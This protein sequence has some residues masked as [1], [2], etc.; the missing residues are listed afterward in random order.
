MG[1]VLSNSIPLAG[2]AAS[3]YMQGMQMKDTHDLAR[4][5]L[6]AMKQSYARNEAEAPYRMNILEGQSSDYAPLGQFADVLNNIVGGEP[7]FQS[8]MSYN[9][10]LDTVGIAAMLKGKSISAA[11]RGSGKDP[12]W[13]R[14][15][16]IDQITTALRNTKTRGLTALD[17][18]KGL[19]DPQYMQGITNNSMSADDVIAKYEAEAN[20]LKQQLY[21]GQATPAGAGPGAGQ[22]APGAG[23]PNKDMLEFQKALDA[24]IDRMK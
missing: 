7:L 16:K 10:A 22:A 21:M 5:N 23:A 8:N 12:R 15:N 14:L 2:G 1:G 11:P 3:G 18:I 13:D 6:A 9:R 20:M 24:A 19:I 17:P 4:Q